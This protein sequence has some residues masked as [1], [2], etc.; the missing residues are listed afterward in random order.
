MIGSRTYILRPYRA[1]D[2]VI[3]TR[4]REI[5]AESFELLKQTGKPDTFLGRQTFE[6]FPKEDD[7]P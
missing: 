2:D 6:P 4:S 3:T 7:N 1:Q 5:I